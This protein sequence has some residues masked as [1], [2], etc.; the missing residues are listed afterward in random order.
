MKPICVDCQAEMNV[1]YNGC[2][3]IEMAKACGG[4]YKIIMAD[5]HRCS[6]CNKRIVARFAQQS[7]TERG[8]PKFEETLE[9]VMRKYQENQTVIV[10]AHEI[11]NGKNL[12]AGLYPS[13]VV[14]NGGTPSATPSA[15]TAPSA[16]PSGS[17]RKIKP[18]WLIDQRYLIATKEQ[19]GCINAD[20]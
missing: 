6:I 15:S 5:M 10:I 7:L 1:S 18:W 17:I 13:S 4:A 20:A 8:D 16:T 9:H 19:G 12:T 2:H 11:V 3:V 14:R